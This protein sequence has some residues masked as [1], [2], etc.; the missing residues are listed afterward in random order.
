LLAAEGRDVILFEAE[1]RPRD[2]SCGGGLRPST[3]NN[4]PHLEALRSKF[5][6]AVTTKGVMGSP[7][8][9][10]ISYTAPEGD[11]PVMFQ[12]RRSVF[13]L[14]LLEDAQDVGAQVEEGMMIV[15]ASGSGRGWHL[16][17]KDGTEVR[18]RG[19]IGAG[20][21]RCPLGR[22]FRAAVSGSQSFPKEQLAVAWAREYHTGEEFVE[23]AFGP[24]RLVRI[25]LREGGLTGYAWVFPKRAH[26]N[27]GFGA[28]VGELGPVDGLALADAYADKLVS[29]GLLPKEP[30]GGVWQAAPIPM[31]GP[32]G[33]MSRPGALSLGDCAGL[34]S[35]LSGDGIYYAMESASLA[36]TVMGSA[37]DIGDLSAKGLAPYGSLV[38]RGIGKELAILSKVAQKVRSDPI[39]M[40]RRARVD[41]SIPPLVVRLFQGEGNV[42]RAAIRLYGKSLLA[43]FRG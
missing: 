37:L 24:E 32:L 31:G 8:G 39:E 16:R 27:V 10:D 21:A 35:P 1:P 25:D 11:L 23:E 9:Q 26:V 18:A 15:S 6:E 30:L 12:V 19:V 43:G 3:L 38:K 40:L 7:G 14:V 17:S 42:R 28:L 2:K 4:F 33:P 34:I 41:P 36:S 5:L 29:I 13:D 20:G 22:R